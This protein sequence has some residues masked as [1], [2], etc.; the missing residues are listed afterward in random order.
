MPLRAKALVD[1]IGDMEQ[2]PSGKIIEAS[3]DLYLEQMKAEDR[4]L[5]EMMVRRKLGGG[6]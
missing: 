6:Q 4:K 1:T 3:L 5:V 2:K